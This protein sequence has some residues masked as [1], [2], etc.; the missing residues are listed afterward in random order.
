M[1][2]QPTYIY[3]ITHVDNLRGILGQD[4]L[5]AHQALGTRRLPYRGIA[6]QS[7]QGRRARTTVPCGPGGNLH[8]YVPFH[9]GPRSPMLY[10]IHSGSVNGYSGSQSEVVHLVSTVEAVL[11][12][13][14]DYVFTD[15]HAI[16]AWTDFYTDP[17]RLDVVDWHLMFGRYWF[18]T[19]EDPDRKR[20]RQAEFLVHC[21]FPWSLVCE[22]GVMN[23][24]I[25]AKVTGLLSGAG[26]PRVTEHRD[27]YY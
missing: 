7:L 10:A 4:G 1:V 22:V 21:F 25:G 15:G 13:G 9:F 3:H 2:P 6:H 19:D 12:A 26:A 27:W 14:L 18:D 8:E 17:S 20:R 16:M 5:W 23:S 24:G 11:Q